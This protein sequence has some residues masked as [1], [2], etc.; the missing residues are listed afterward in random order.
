M[1]RSDMGD[2]EWGIWNGNSSNRCLPTNHAASN[3]LMTGG[4]STGFSTSCARASTGRICPAN[5]AH[6]PRSA[7]AS[8]GGLTR[9]TGTVSW[10]RWPMRTTWTQLWSMALPCAFIIRQPRQKNDPR[11]CMGRSQGGLAT[12][13]HALANQD[14]LPVRFELTPGQHVLADKACDADWIREMIREQGAMDVIPSRSNRRM[15]K[16]FDAD[17]DKD[18]N[19]TERFPGRLK[20]SFRRIATRY[21]K[22]S[23]NFLAMVKLAS[24]RLSIKSYEPA[25]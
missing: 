7:T 16:D 18:R 22:T 10:K 3:G 9:G 23:R 5:T 4:S 14:G 6:Q 13:I 19:K 15:P 21:G 2:L 12:R 8:T 20:A 25:A 1:A 24:V 11:R 17:I